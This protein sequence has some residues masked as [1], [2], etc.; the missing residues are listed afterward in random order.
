MLYCEDI[1]PAL[2]K[3]RDIGTI[4]LGSILHMKCIGIEFNYTMAMPT[5][6]LSGLAAD[7]WSYYEVI[8]N[9]YCS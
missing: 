4:R 9:S 3:N 1:V 2:L 7:Q 5:N 8:H 6:V